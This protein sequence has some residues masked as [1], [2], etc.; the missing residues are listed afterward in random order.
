M[1]YAFLLQFFFH[2][3]KSLVV[4]VLCRFEGTSQ[5]DYQ[6]NPTLEKAERHCKTH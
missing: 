3:R 6:T 1:E 2:F 5:R 4:D